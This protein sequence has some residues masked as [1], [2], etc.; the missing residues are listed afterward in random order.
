MKGLREQLAAVRSRHAVELKSPIDGVVIP[1]HTR[2]SEVLH[3]RPGEQVLRRAEEVVAAGDAILAVSQQEPN[4]IVAYANEYQ[5]EW[6]AKLTTV[7][8]VKTRTPPQV[9]LAEIR[10]VGPTLELL[11]QRLWSNP[12]VPQWGRPVLIN[13]PP[14]LDL[15]AGEVVG[16]RGS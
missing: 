16:I 4:E 10:S 12:S 9:A 7:E 15:V 13:I 6:L 8:V 3:Q 5:L 11:P 1:I 2:N 14:G